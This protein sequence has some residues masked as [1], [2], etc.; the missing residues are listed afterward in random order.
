MS[1][2][3]LEV[4]EGDVS[5]ESYT[6]RLDTLPSATVT[7]TVSGHAGSDVSVSATA[8]TFSTA[9]WDTVQ[10]VTVTA[11]HDADATNDTVTLSHGAS[12]GGYGS[13]S[14]VTV[15]VTV[16]DDDSAG[17]D[18]SVSSLEVDEGDVSGES[19]TVRLDTSPSATVTG[20]CVGPCR[21]RCVGVG[22]LVDVHHREL[23]HRPD[24]D[25]DRRA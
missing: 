4:D 1:V 16:D 7:V 25:G 14:A 2:A 10:T 22:D 3:S 21:Q 24:G 9:N 18:L 11:A 5:G 17:I 19:Y 8:L 13:V 20:H 23:G 6:V 15:A 12:G